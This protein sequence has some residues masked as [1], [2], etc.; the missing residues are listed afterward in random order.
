MQTQQLPTELQ[1]AQHLSKKLQNA[2]GIAK[3]FKL[4]K[5]S[6]DIEEAQELIDLLEDSL[7]TAMQFG[8]DL[9]EFDGTIQPPS[10]VQPKR[11]GW[12]S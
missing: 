9:Q 12:G 10:R 11:I 8:V 4:H 6:I 1:R 5:A 3:R 7:K 2:I